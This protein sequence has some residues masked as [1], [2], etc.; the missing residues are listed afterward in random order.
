MKILFLYIFAV[1][2]IILMVLLTIFSLTYSKRNYAT[3]LPDGSSLIKSKDFYKEKYTETLNYLSA[4]YPTAI[5]NF[6]EMNEIELAVFFNSLWYY[7]NC[8]ASY[9]S[10]SQAKINQCWQK[11]PGCGGKYPK[12]PY[13]P[14]G[15]I[16]SFSDWI[17]GSFPEEGN[18]SQYVFSDSSLSPS[19]YSS[20]TPG[21]TL[22]AWLVGPGTLFTVQRSLTRNVFAEESYINPPEIVSGKIGGYSRKWNYPE[23]W[24]LGSKIIEVTY[25][26]VI[27]GGV[28]AIVWWNGAPGSGI[29]LDCGKSKIARNKADGV[30]ELVKEMIKTK[31]GKDALMKWYGFTD[32]Y[33]IIACLIQQ[34]CKQNGFYVWDYSS[35][36]RTQINI[37]GSTNM[38]YSLPISQGGWNNLATFLPVD[39]YRWCSNK[40][41]DPNRSWAYGINNDCLERIIKGIEYPADRISSSGC[42]DEALT[43][44]GVFLGYDTVQLTNSANG[45]GGWQVEILELRGLPLEVKY[46]D[47]SRYVYVEKTNNNLLWRKDTD[48]IEKYMK[49]IFNYITLRNPFDISNSKYI[50][51]CE[52]IE[53]Y[54]YNEQTTTNWTWNI[55]SKNHISDMYFRLNINGAND[56]EPPIWNQC[57]PNGIGSDG[58]IM[59]DDTVPPYG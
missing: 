34:P 20:N 6:R 35:N 18:W 3:S 33:D 52:P 24:W 29:F 40:T 56:Q 19:Y 49:S 1:F 25:S 26:V 48:F 11:L 58:K 50:R 23:R 7:Y 55:A 13:S 17:K 2:L 31:D 36:S 43:V 37:C 15:Y 51:N 10:P 53:D 44:M 42:F 12:L 4:V 57:S 9:K 41:S 45:S 28:G 16:Y 21:I 47:Y 27:P 39:W 8:E 30:F 32:P 5:D 59:I 38:F 54:K 22:W 46:R 14:Q